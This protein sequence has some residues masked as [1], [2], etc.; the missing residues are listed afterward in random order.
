M[1]RLG[2]QGV[3][4]FA[5]SSF[6]PDKK[7]NM[8]RCVFS[9]RCKQSSLPRL[10]AGTLAPRGVKCPTSSHLRQRTSL[11]SLSYCLSP[12]R[13]RRA[14]TCVHNT[15]LAASA[16]HRAS[17]TSTCTPQRRAS[18]PTRLSCHNTPKRLALPHSSRPPR[19]HNKPTPFTQAH[20]SAR[21]RF[22]Q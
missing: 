7:M 4:C 13:D 17:N 14:L 16:P 1:S 2:S 9:V 12:Q 15:R 5:W 22:P 18:H 6:D 11:D 20:L 10:E 8:P 3:E 19:P 21:S